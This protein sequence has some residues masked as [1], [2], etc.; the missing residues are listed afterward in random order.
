MIICFNCT[1]ETKDELD[2]MVAS[3]SYRDYGEAIAA[4]IRNQ[5]LMEQEIAAKGSLV[6]NAPSSLPLQPLPEPVSDAPAPVKPAAA[7]KAAKKTA[8]PRRASSVAKDSN[9]GVMELFEPGLCL[10]SRRR[11]RAFK[12]DGFPTKPP[13]GLAELPSD[14]WA[15]GQ[16]VPAR[17]LGPGSA[18]PSSAGEGQFPGS[19]PALRRE[20]KGAADRAT[21]RT[22]R[23]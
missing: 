9:N 18:Q 12:R 2:R 23:L 5:V 7:A 17:P 8:S 22:T 16:A 10:G 3:G 19:Y 13:K 6:I 21:A 20:L 15:P 11:T 1:A 4:S 14:M